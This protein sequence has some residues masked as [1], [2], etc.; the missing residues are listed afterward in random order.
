LADAFVN[1]AHCRL[2]FGDFEGGWIK[3]EWRWQSLRQK[4]AARDLAQPLW[5][6]DAVI[7]GKRILL[8]AEQGYGDT[9]QM[10][11][12]A[13]MVSQLGA[14]VIL[15][16]PA[17]L[18]ELVQSIGRNIQVVQFNQP[19]DAFDFQTPLLS[20]PLAF[21]TTL[22]TIPAAV[23]YLSADPAKAAYWKDRLR[24]TED[25]RL[26]VGIA[27][28]GNPIHKNDRRRSMPLDRFAPL[29]DYADFFIIQTDL[30]DIDRRF[31]NQMPGL[32][33]LGAEFADFSDTA[34]A[35]ANLDLVISVDTSLVHLAGSM[36]KPVWVLL[37]VD[38]DWRWLLDREDS[39]WYPTASLFRQTT[40]GDWSGVIARAADRLSQLADRR[41]PLQAV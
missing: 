1:E 40:L 38:S 41:L 27:C 25:G 13:P 8:H 11:R 35:V 23:P 26:K 33:Y 22:Q 12:Y 39:P 24:T 18:K 31:L 16:V 34:A 14:Q 4:G 7:A 17:P 3:H 6:G 15:S 37:S 28:S 36:A 5:L 2:L 19:I 30:P 32:A 9:L 21:H 20:L 10:C 29:L